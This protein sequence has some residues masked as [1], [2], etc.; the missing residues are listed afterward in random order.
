[1][2]PHFYISNSALSHLAIPI[3]ASNAAA[4]FPSPRVPSLGRR[5]G[6]RGEGN[7]AAALEAIPIT[8]KENRFSIS[9]LSRI[10]TAT[11]CA[12]QQL[13]IC[14]RNCRIHIN[15]NNRLSCVCGDS[16]VKKEALVAQFVVL[17]YY[18]S[19]TILKRYA[20]YFC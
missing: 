8:N 7:K 20:Q 6:T 1:M 17:V 9:V 5:E 10:S 18:E 14:F 19:G 16:R 12:K 3:I 15:C 4:L 2:H 11:N 13:P